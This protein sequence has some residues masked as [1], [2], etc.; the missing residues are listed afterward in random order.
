M[1]RVWPFVF[2]AL[3]GC[4]ASLRRLALTCNSTLTSDPWLLSLPSLRN[5]TLTGAAVTLPKELTAL[6]CLTR[7]EFHDCTVVSAEG[8]PAGLSELYFMHTQ[9]RVL[10]ASLSSLSSLTGLEFSAV[11]LSAA[12]L[13]ILSSLASLKSLVLVGTSIT[14]VPMTLTALRSL[15]SLFLEDARIPQADIDA[16]LSGLPPLERLGLQSCDLDMLPPSLSGRAGN[17]TTLFFDRNDATLLL[18]GGS[19]AVCDS[20]KKL[21]LSL[22]CLP[23]LLNDLAKCTQ[24]HALYIWRDDAAGLD[25][26]QVD[27]VVSTLASHSA[28]T[29]VG[30]VG[31]EDEAESFHVLRLLLRLAGAAPKL[32]VD[33]LEFDDVSWG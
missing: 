32:R 12:D 33:V 28:L 20:V 24:L 10:P 19:S 29:F 3:A 9:L 8:L 30:I 15:D 31:E 4:S 23:T 7:L 1:R 5:L 17:L 21:G 6:T 26:S 22:G 18:A 25:A 16:L 14:S 2:A 13:N 27:E 11:D